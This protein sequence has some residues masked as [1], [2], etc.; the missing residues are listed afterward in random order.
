MVLA[1]LFVAVLGLIGWRHS[2]DGDLVYRGKPFGK[3]LDDLNSSSPEIRASAKGC[4]RQS[5]DN[6]V[7]PHFCRGIAHRFAAKGAA[8]RPVKRQSVVKFR[9]ESASDYQ[10]KALR[11]FR[12][13]GKTGALGLARG[14]TNHNQWIRFGCV[15]RWEM[16]SDY[17]A[18][19][20]QPLFSPVKDNEPMIRSRA[21]KALGML[22][23][24]PQLVV[25]Q[26]LP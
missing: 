2:G 19:L 17:P 15:G 3:W 7:L 22:H 9:L 16:C 25:Q 18:I 6:A 21:A 20:F 11:G 10:S 24:Q 14:F 4:I 5:W 13:L 12:A 1:I 26:P 8:L 23:Q